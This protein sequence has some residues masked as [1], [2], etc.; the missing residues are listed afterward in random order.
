[1]WLG[2]RWAGEVARYIRLV[3]AILRGEGDGDGDGVG[4]A[5]LLFARSR[6]D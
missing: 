5:G 2:C 3:P 1:M 4:D 6:T